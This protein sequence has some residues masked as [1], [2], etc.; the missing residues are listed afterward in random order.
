VRKRILAGLP[1]GRDHR[2]LRAGHEERAVVVRREVDAIADHHFN[3]SC[4]LM[5]FTSPVPAFAAAG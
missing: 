4:F 3:P 5:A 1:E 2:Q